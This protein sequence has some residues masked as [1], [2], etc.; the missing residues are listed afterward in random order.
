[1]RAGT[2]V[3]RDDRVLRGTRWLSAF[4]A[5]FLL[6]AFVLLYVLPA[7][8]ER[9]FAWTITPTMTPMALAAAY[10]GGA[11]YFVRA[12]R[13]RRW[14]SIKAGLPPVAIFA[15][16]LG[17][18]TVL[19]WDRFNHTHPAFWVWT[20][21]YATA[22][23]LVAWAWLANRR[24]AA[25]ADAD[26]AADVVATGSGQAVGP[27]ARGLAAVAGVVAFGWGAVMFIA[28]TAIIPLWPWALTPLTCRVLAA[29]FCLGIAGLWIAA[30]PRWVAVQL[31]LQ[32]EII[33]VGLIIL[34]AARA[35]SELLLDR[36][37]TW[38]FLGGSTTL[39]LSSVVLWLAHTKGPHLTGHVLSG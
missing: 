9:L 27:V 18:A 4:I 39:L 14:A 19:H 12:V 20:F 11:Y 24:Y 7:D 38:V 3:S 6:V 25:P 32:V 5:P 1:M 15:T 37:L 13:A 34:A 2:D 17:I 26:T 33:M 10:L 36:P 29:I 22:P 8:T 23:F 28:P 16:L 21:L 31:M 35:H 30:D